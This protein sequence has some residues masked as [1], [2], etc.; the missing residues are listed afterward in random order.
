MR[1][2][3][4]N[5]LC[6]SIAIT[7]IQT[8]TIVQY[9]H[10]YQPRPLGAST[11]SVSAHIFSQRTGADSVAGCSQSPER[12][13]EHRPRQSHTAPSQSEQVA[14]EADLIIARATCSW[15]STPPRSESQKSNHPPRSSTN[16]GGTE[17]ADRPGRARR[18]NASTR[19]APVLLSATEQ[20]I[21]RT[22]VRR[23]IS[24]RRI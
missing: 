4:A 9:T 21:S 24:T 23:Q 13:S 17:S 5:F 18:T 10:K 16:E 3:N 11:V 22:V 8:R 19:S 12:Q 6:A 7:L 15:V 1:N 20:N 2:P 14:T